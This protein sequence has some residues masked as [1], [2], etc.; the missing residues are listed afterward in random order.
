MAPRKHGRKG[1]MKTNYALEVQDLLNLLTYI[2]DD[3]GV[4]ITVSHSP[5]LLEVQRI[6]EEH[7]NPSERK[8]IKKYFIDKLFNLW[9]TEGITVQEL[10]NQS[11]SFFDPDL[12][13]FVLASKNLDEKQKKDYLNTVADVLYAPQTLT[14]KQQVKLGAMMISIFRLLL[15]AVVERDG[16]PMK[17]PYKYEHPPII[18]S[19]KP[20]GK[21][22]RGKAMPND[23][24][25]SQQIAKQSYNLTDPQKDIDGWILQTWS[26]N[27]KIY[28]KGNVGILGVRGTKTAEDVSV[29]PTV[30]L[31]TLGS[32]DLYK[33]IE[34][35][36]MKFKSENP[37]I[38]EYYAV[39][40]SLGGAFI[41]VML[42]KGIVKEAVSFNPA[43]QYNDINGGLPNRRIYYGAD[44]MY[45]LMGW[46]DKKS[47]HRD[48]DMFS[49]FISSMVDNPVTSM[50]SAHKLSNFIGGRKCR[51]CGLMK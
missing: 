7:S 8:N 28:T 33:R 44:P 16:M 29:W 11:E 37:E 31:N 50:L 42:R 24:N 2:Y 43:I 48:T 51:K 27:L 19:K 40:H 32:T 23:L 10:H 25:I 15:L 1:G 12:Q 22:R 49:K 4:V 39:G 30:T 20:D 14:L 35:E 41:D 17:T 38:T 13:D 46:W 21:G 36:F 5:V 3:D 18:P 26:P 9:N 34:G 47:E 45:R 6:L